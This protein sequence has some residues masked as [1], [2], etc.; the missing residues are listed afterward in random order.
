MTAVDIKCTLAIAGLVLCVLQCR[1]MYQHSLLILVV[2]ILSSGALSSAQDDLIYKVFPV[3]ISCNRNAT[4][5]QM[6]RNEI[7]L[8]TGRTTL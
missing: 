2:I 8:R 7:N 4:V 1:K 3:N 5:R 6:E